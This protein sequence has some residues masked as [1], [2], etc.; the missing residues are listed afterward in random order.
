MVDLLGHVGHLQEVE[1][2]V[3]AMPRKQQVAARMALLGACRIQGNVEMGEHIAKQIVE[4]EPKN[5]AAYVLL[6]NIYATASNRH[7]CNYVEQ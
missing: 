3:M 2:M 1:N 5:T 6:S 4:M 7:L